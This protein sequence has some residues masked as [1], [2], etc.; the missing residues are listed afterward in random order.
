MSSFV[1]IVNQGDR[2][3]I[4][5]RFH[6]LNINIMGLFY[7]RGTPVTESVIKQQPEL[8]CS[9]HQK[10][11]IGLCIQKGCSKALMIC[12]QC[13]TDADGHRC[14]MLSLES[15]KESIKAFVEH[16]D[17]RVKEV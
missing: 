3:L 2:L 7:S 1:Q 4:Q 11:A 9:Q 8:E 15:V 10:E 12:S 17:P 14:S 16:S 5:I 6:R 13:M